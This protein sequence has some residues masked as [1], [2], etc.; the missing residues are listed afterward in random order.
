[1]TGPIPHTIPPY[2]PSKIKEDRKTLAHPENMQDGQ[3]LALIKD[4]LKTADRETLIVV[5]EVLREN[6]WDFQET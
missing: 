2:T 5:L 1:M 6:T 4:Y 3:I